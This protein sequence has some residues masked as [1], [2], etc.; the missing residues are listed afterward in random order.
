LTD[1]RDQRLDVSWIVTDRAVL[2]I[3]CALRSVKITASNAVIL[4]VTLGLVACSGEA[5]LLEYSPDIDRHHLL[6]FGQ[7]ALLASGLQFAINI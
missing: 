7:A 3:A 2:S 6:R 1:R 4:L 5:V